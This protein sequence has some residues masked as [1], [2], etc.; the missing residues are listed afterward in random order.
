MTCSPQAVAH[1]F[2]SLDELVPEVSVCIANW[3]CR[4]LLRACLRSLLRAPQDVSLEVVVVDNA[5]SDGAAEMVA[6]E[7]PEA[8]LV[9]NA[10]NRG[11]AAANNQAAA[12]ARGA[13]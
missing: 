1:A 11:F 6:Q 3:N 2:Y 10:V 9:R 7:F 4:E 5:S 13:Y 12:Q 8:R